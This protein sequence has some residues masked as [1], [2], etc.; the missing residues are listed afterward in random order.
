MNQSELVD[1]VAQKT[2]LTHAAAAEAVK[3]VVQAVLESLVAGDPVRVSG[4][5]TVNVA[6]RPAPEGRNPQTGKVLKFRPARQCGSTQGRPPKMPSTHHQ[7][8]AIRS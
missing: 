1:K 2:T 4:L 3:A 6:G 8:L 5:V 7:A